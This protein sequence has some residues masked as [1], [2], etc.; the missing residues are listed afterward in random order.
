MTSTDDE[1]PEVIKELRR[2]WDLIRY[3]GAE[4][5][6]ATARAEV[7]A[8]AMRR[9]PDCVPVRRATPRTAWRWTNRWGRRAD[10]EDVAAAVL[11]DR[12]GSMDQLKDAVE[13]TPRGPE[14]LNRL[15]TRWD[16]LHRPVMRH[17]VTS[18][19]GKRENLIAEAIERLPEV[20]RYIDSRRFPRP[21]DAP[22]C[23]WSQETRRESIAEAVLK[24]EAGA[25]DRLCGSMVPPVVRSGLD[26][27]E[28]MQRQW[29][30]LREPVRDL[31]L[32]RY[33]ETF[34]PETGTTEDI[35]LE[36]V[37]AAWHARR[38]EL[39]AYAIGRLPAI[40]AEIASSLEWRNDENRED[41]ARAVLDGDEGAI[42]RLL[43]AMA[44]SGNRF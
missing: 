5:E 27:L 16:E 9:L 31:G 10:P 43:N 33:A 13:R 24:D 39:M 4:E 15:R 32:L 30:S 20:V 11:N 21:E 19:Q 37:N 25:M 6:R 26:V 41:V 36:S 2:D 8:E 1:V 29:A 22:V 38:D 42:R 23:E 7:I 3:A 34:D 40:A 28:E 17:Q 18:V 44:P 35:T 14:V 12:P